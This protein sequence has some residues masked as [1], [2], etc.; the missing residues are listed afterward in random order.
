VF[1]TSLCREYYQLF[2]AQAV[3]L[4]VGMAFVT[5]PPIGVV[6]RAMPAHRGL[7]LGIVVGGSSLGGVVWPI[8]LERLLNHTSLGFGWVMRIV[9]FAMLPLLAIACATVTEERRAVTAKTTPGSDVSAAMTGVGAEEEL[10]DTPPMR[11]KKGQSEIWMLMKNKIFIFLS[12]GLAVAYFGLFVPFFYV[13]SYAT[14]MGVSPQ[15]SFYLISALNG[16]SLVGRVLPGYLADRWGHYN[17]IIMAML[18]STV[19]AFAWTAAS[20]LAGII[21]VAVTYGFASGV[22]IYSNRRNGDGADKLYM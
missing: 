21:V 4:G 20:S 22:S 11:E 19:V 9:G 15:T 16:A 3:L 13:S 12:L 10:S 17:L 5:W 2:L 7:A 8:V 18:A 6:G 14:E 1:L